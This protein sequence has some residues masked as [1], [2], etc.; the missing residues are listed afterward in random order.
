M[1]R[2]GHRCEYWKAYLDNLLYPKVLV[3]TIWDC[4]GEGR[5]RDSWRHIWKCYVPLDVPC[6][7]GVIGITSFLF[8][9]SFFLYFRYNQEL[10]RSFYPYPYPLFFYY[11][12]LVLSWR[13]TAF[14]LY[15]SI[16]TRGLKFML[17]GHGW[18]L[19]SKAPPH[20]PFL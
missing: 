12:F 8:L 20:E 2:G 9:F 10:I 15:F 11:W 5:R 6:L 17:I 13:C 16:S 7:I 3:G 18:V 14:L 19:G 1:E 4:I